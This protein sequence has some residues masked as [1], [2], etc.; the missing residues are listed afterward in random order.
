MRKFLFCGVLFI[1]FCLAAA[2][3]EAGEY[4][5]GPNDVLGITVYRESELSRTVRVSSDGCISYPLLGKV[6]VEGLT[7]F[8]LENDLTER[9]KKY[10][11]NPQVTVFIQRYSTITVSGQV[12]KPGAY[13]LKEDLTVI[14]AIS[15]AGGFTKIAAR[16]DVKIMRVEDGKKKT[17]RVKVADISKK[18]DLTQDVPLKR[19]DVVF[20]PES[21]F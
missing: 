2:S 5:L 1:A 3:I 21:L 15:L 10:L 8:E 18:G 4:R 11:K 20:V 14:E 13:P 6:K 12:E 9:L 17:I 16:N 7:V 19:G